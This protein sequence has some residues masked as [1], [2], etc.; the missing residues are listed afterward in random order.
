MKNKE[1][2]IG[3]LTRLF[4]YATIQEGNQYAELFIPADKWHETAQILKSNDSIPFDYLISLTAVDYLT[5]FTV[6]YHLESTSTHD[7]I[8]VK[9]DVENREDPQI[10]TVSDIWIT[11]EFHEREV[12]D[13]FGIRFN[14]HPDL[15]R[16]F[17]EEDDGYPLR[18]DFKDEINIIELPN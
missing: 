14:H 4:P 13:L 2:L 9:T 3:F 11:A 17:M 16:F 8:V 10:D 1:E 15:R 12:Y 7:F 18:K 5:K 6:V